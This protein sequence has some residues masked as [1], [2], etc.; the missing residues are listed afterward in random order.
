MKLRCVTNSIRIRA[1]KSDLAILKSEGEVVDSVHFGGSQWLVFG[2]RMAE[3]ISEVQAIFT[4]GKIEVLLPK[5]I[6]QR[7]MASHQVGIHH[8]IPLEN[9]QQLEILIEKDFPCAHR[10]TEDKSDTFTELAPS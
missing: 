6:G 10:P 8:H 9:N 3:E 2:L 1:R 5:E 4:E 7:W